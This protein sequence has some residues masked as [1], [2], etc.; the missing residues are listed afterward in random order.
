MFIENM[1]HAKN[2]R[3][4]LVG[5]LMGLIM[6]SLVATFAYV[7]SDF[8]VSADTSSD[9]LA[10]AE[11]TAESAAS[12]AKSAKDDMEAQGTAA[13]AYIS[14]ATYQDL[15]LE[16]NAKSYEK[17]LKYGQA[18][19]AACAN[20]DK[21]D[22]ETAYGYIFSAYQGLDDAKG[23]SAAF[24]ESINNFD[25]TQSY[26]DS[27]YSAMSALGANEQFVTD[28][29]A[30]TSLLNDKQAEEEAAGGSEEAAE[31]EKSEDSKDGEDTGTEEVST[32]DLIAYVAQL[33][34]QA[35]ATT[36]ETT[37]N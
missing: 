21:P 22:Y 15:F 36:S 4:F 25:I 24:N 16:D 19:V 1:R 32:S 3:R 31:D 18:M 20:A 12:E 2:K 23:L 10:T 37:E 11:S 27:Y 6:I 30:V 17:A 28:M 5:I 26:L 33:V 14:L 29:K 7:G 35:T 13:S 34:S 9:Y 8:G